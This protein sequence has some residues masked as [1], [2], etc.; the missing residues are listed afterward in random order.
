MAV[1]NRSRLLEARMTKRNDELLRKAA[2]KCGLKLE[3]VLS[4]IL[5]G[6]ID[7]AWYAMSKRLKVFEKLKIN[8][9]IE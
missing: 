8:P 2:K 1:K 4:L 5:Q 3:E 7:I 9:T 6:E